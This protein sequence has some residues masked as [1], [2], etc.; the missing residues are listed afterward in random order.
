MQKLLNIV[1]YLQTNIDILDIT[2]SI[3]P[4]KETYQRTNFSNRHSERN[5]DQPLHAITLVSGEKDDFFSSSAPYCIKGNLIL[6]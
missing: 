3:Y 6:Y 1:E 5:C 2:V 4:L